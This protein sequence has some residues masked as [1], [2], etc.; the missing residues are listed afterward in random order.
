MTI[1][2]DNRPGDRATAARDNPMNLSALAYDRLEEMIVTCALRPGLF[3]SI[4]DLQAATGL[5]R[6]PM[7][8][9]VSQLAADTLILIR[10]RHGLQTRP[11]R[12]GAG[13]HPARLAAGHG[14]LRGAAGHRAGEFRAGVSN[15]R[16][17]PMRYAAGAMA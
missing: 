16:R 4:Q 10:P 3:L 12:P 2:P 17:L 8:Q 9:A 14:A 1:R 7:H 11:H 15:S 13:A 6:T 5:G